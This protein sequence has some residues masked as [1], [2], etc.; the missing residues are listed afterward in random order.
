MSDE[1]NGMGEV[2]RPPSFLMDLERRLEAVEQRSLEII[3]MQR[4]LDE[5]TARLRDL[6][7]NQKTLMSKIDKILRAVEQGKWVL[8]GAMLYM[9]ASQSGFLG[10]LKAVL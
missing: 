6:E 9:V 5:H 7:S 2:Q 10:F 8:M 1:D 3:P 4:V